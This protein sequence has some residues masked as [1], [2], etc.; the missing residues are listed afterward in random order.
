MRN[1]ETILK[2]IIGQYVIQIASAQAKIEE[3]EEQ[4]K[5]LTGQLIDKQVSNNG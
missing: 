5:I 4:N 2:D 1:A 3:L